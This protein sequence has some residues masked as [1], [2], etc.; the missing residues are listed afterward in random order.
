MAFDEIEL[1]LRVGFGSK[2]GPNFST[3]I[4]TVDSGYER[5]NQNWAQARRVYDARTGV[6]S[7]ADAATLLTFFHARAGRARGFRLK[8]WSDYSSAA[9]N[10]STPSFTDQTIA[11]GDGST[12]V[13]QLVKNYSSGGMTHTRIIT[14]PVS[15][16]V[17]IG[18]GGTQMSSGWSVDSTTGLVT[19][20]TAPTAGQSITAGF[21]FDVPVRFDTDYLALSAENYVA[22]QADVP[23]VEIRI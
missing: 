22:Y 1:P 10:L 21:L 16:S 2:G 9:D 4:I 17:I 12:V 15:G 6:R 19:F 13:F 3:E 5:S 20:A 8:D 14:K 23:I 11:T 18:A 7:T